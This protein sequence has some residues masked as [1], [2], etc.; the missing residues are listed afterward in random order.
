[1]TNPRT[2]LLSI[3]ATALSF[4]LI[5]SASIGMTRGAP[6]QA[7]L[8]PISTMV[9]DTTYVANIEEPLDFD[10]LVPGHPPLPGTQAHVAEMRQYLED[11][12]AAVRAV[13]EQALVESVRME[14]ESAYRS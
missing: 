6:E 7:T 12:I 4:L 2:L 1:M 11:L 5:L 14:M 13:Q 3:G 10:T 9:D 8:L